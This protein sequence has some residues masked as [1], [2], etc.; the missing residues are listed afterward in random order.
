MPKK[1]ANYTIPQDFQ[2]Q[3]NTELQNYQNLAP[4]AASQVLADQQR[5]GNYRDTPAA[6]IERQGLADAGARFGQRASL[7]RIN[8]LQQSLGIPVTPSGQLP[9]TTT[10]P[11]VQANT[12]SPTNP[13][14]GA[15]NT[16]GID[17]RT[18]LPMA[19]VTQFVN[20]QTP[21]LGTLPAPT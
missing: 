18:G 20:P 21:T 9:S 5:E 19:P 13:T 10:T 12:V 2:G 7:A 1:I 15:V 6:N 17:P 8:S 14:T 4:A 16:Q 3:L 11:A